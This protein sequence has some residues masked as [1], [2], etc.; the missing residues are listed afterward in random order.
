M[1]SF[2]LSFSQQYSSVVCPT[3]V[4]CCFVF[5]LLLFGDAEN[6]PIVIIRFKIGVPSYVNVSSMNYNYL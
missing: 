2:F 1:S 5:S 3:R 4:D 6:G